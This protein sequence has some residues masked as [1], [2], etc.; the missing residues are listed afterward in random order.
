M[1]LHHKVS[2]DIPRC[3]KSKPQVRVKKPAW[4]V[5]LLNVH[6]WPLW[7]CCAP[8]KPADLPW[9]SQL[10]RSINSHQQFPLLFPLMRSFTFTLDRFTPLFVNLFILFSPLSSSRGQQTSGGALKETEARHRERRNQLPVGEEGW[11]LQ[12][13]NP[14]HFTPACVPR[15]WC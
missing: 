11:P 4:P 12:W 10:T 13:R 8:L 14:Y 6:L 9:R 15:V 2:H 7:P 1:A 3:R 5:D